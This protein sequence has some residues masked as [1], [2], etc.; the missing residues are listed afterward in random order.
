[1]WMVV[2]GM[3][4]AEGL[5]AVWFTTLCW[6]TGIRFAN[7]WPIGVVHANTTFRTCDGGTGSQAA[8][9]KFARM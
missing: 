2:V 7:L 1:M 8:F 4:V 6:L 3:R 5:F 9:R